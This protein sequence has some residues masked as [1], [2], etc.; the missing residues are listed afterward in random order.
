MTKEEFAEFLKVE[1]NKGLFVEAA[2][3]MG[4]EAPEEIEGLKKNNRELKAEKT[5]AKSEL[6]DLKKRLDEIEDEK[7]LDN[8]DNK[9]PDPKL[10][11][12]YEKLKKELEE[13]TNKA[14]QIEGAY[15]STLIES[16]ISKALEKTGFN[17]HKDL[18]KK[19]YLGNAKIEV[20]GDKRTI[21]ILD[22]EQELPAEEFFK[23]KAASDLKDYL[24]KPV[25]SGAGAHGF[26]GASGS[27]VISEG[28]FKNLTPKA[29]ASFMEGG[30]KIE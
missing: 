27:K 7:Y 22:G 29:R 2:K 1:E 19:A 12:E 28:D 13:A 21:L 6:D 16:T 11:R 4:F 8:K 26:T 9:T 15:N 5:K 14:K 10:Q 30:G 23:Q 20:E 25:N 24:D 3:A 18:L 17:Q